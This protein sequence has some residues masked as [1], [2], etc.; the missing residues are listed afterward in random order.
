MLIYYLIK[1]LLP[2]MCEEGLNWIKIDEKSIKMEY[3][4]PNNSLFKPDQNQNLLWQ[5]AQLEFKDPM[6]ILNNCVN[7]KPIL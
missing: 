1:L 5:E 3:F 7:K 4:K 6:N 2:S